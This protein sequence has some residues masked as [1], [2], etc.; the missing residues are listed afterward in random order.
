MMDE[1]GRKAPKGTE[2]KM[3]KKIVDKKRVEEKRIEIFLR[4]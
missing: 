4:F 1:N 3:R 2:K